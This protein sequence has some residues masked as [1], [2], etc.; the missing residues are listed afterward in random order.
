MLSVVVPVRDE[1]SHLAATVDALLT[2]LDGSGFDAELVIVDDGSSDGS[3]DVARLTVNGQVPLSVV[4]LGGEGRFEARRAGLQAATGE[5]AL[6]LDARVRLEPDALSFLHERVTDGERVWNGHVHVESESALGTFW[7]LLAELAWRD[8]FDDPRTTS[9]G[10]E[11][12]DRFPKGTTCFA[13]PRE[14]LLTAFAAFSTGYRDARLANDDTPILRTV[15][16]QTRIGISPHFACRYAPRTSLGRFLGH[17][18]HRG[19]V[20]VDGHGTPASRF[21]PAVV[22]FFPISAALAL[23]ALRR[24][25]IAPAAVAG[26]G[27]AAAAYGLYAGRS[28]RELAVLATVTPLYAIGHGLGMW[29]G[30][31]E[32]LRGGRAR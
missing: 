32:L 4:H 7:S 16:A 5:L 9:F 18:I 29:R 10:E 12:F 6:L 17:A 25:A 24:P 23:A 30:A 21:F 2:A 20:F 28:R 11:D 14:V 26:T 27:L 15:A 8:Y 3:A 19:T 22:A 31:F 1:A 13:A